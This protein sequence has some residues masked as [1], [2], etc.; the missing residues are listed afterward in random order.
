[1][2]VCNNHD[3]TRLMASFLHSIEQLAEM[4]RELRFLGVH[5]RESIGRSS[6]LAVFVL[7]R[8]G[9]DVNEAFDAVEAAR[10]CSIPD[11][12]EQRTVGYRER[13]RVA[14]MRCW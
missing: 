2:P 5:C 4:V 11:A 7:V 3:Q 9:C 14:V 12:P 13:S 8:L 1:M 10:G 6:V